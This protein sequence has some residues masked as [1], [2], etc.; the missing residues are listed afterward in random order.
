M[1]NKNIVQTVVS[2]FLFKRNV[3]LLWLKIPVVLTIFLA[4]KKR[5]TISG[6]VELYLLKFEM[7]I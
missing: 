6:I 2:A 3:L 4:T 1:K 5:D 7:Y